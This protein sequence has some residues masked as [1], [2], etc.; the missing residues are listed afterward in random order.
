[1]GSSVRLM[2]GADELALD[3][4]P[5]GVLHEDDE[6]RCA[7]RRD[8]RG[9]SCGQSSAAGWG[10]ARGGLARFSAR[11]LFVPACPPAGLARAAPVAGRFARLE[12]SRD[13]LLAVLA[14]LGESR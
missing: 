1:M 2:Y 13:H 11:L 14:A 9:S 12:L 4:R 6:H 7:P 8:E 10:R 3:A 5:V